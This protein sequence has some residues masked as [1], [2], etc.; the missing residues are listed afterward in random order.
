MITLNIENS[1]HEAVKSIGFIHGLLHGQSLPC[2]SALKDCPQ[3]PT[4][5]QEGDVYTHTKLVCEALPNLPEFQ[6][7]PENEQVILLAACLFHDT[8]KPSTTKH[9][10]GGSISHPYHAFHGCRITRKALYQLNIEFPAR[11]LVC[12]L[13]RW[14]MKPTFALE[15]PDPIKYISELT[16]SSRA[17]LLAIL[18]KSDNTGKIPRSDDNLLKIDLFLEQAKELGCLDKPFKF[19]SDHARY[20]FFNRD[21]WDAY[22][23][24]H[25]DTRC[26]VTIMSGLPGAGK[27]HWIEQNLPKLPQVS[28]DALRHDLKVKPTD[29]QTPVMQAAKAKAKYFLGKARDFVWNATN[30]SIVQRH[31]CM[32]LF[33]RYNAKLHVVYV[34]TDYENL[35][36]QNKARIDPVPEDVIDKLMDKWHLPL[37]TEAHIV[38]YVINNQTMTFPEILGML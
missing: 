16:F 17:D 30:L 35:L 3:D 27:D 33:K 11:E 4:H 13:V 37:S 23:D 32:K 7:I 31:Q 19:N 5:H 26:T 18:A 15:A 24:A 9:N 38:E 1:R 10:D 36:K 22:N 20:V 29:D 6:K 28:L 8:G 14:H 12:H 21:D 2:I 34:E 25:D